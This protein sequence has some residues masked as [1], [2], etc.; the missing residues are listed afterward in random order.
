MRKYQIYISDTAKLDILSIY[1]YISNT[2]NSPNTA[3][4]YLKY[5]EREIR[6]LEILPERFRRYQ[7]TNEML[8]NTRMMPIKNYVVFYRVSNIDMRV[9]IIRVLF[10]KQN[11]TSLI[12]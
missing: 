5:I 1:N 7:E 6:M 11:Y 3:E 9:D 8:K 4:K 12:E 10:S 2:L